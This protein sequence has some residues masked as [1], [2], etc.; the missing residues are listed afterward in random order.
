MKLLAFGLVILGVV[1]LIYGGI[2]YSHE[3]TVLEVAGIKATATEHKTVPL[4][5]VAG[6]VALV[7]G[8][9]LLLVDRRRAA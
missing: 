6:A 7:G 9:A 8:L 4:P 2:G 1:A 5:P 3:K